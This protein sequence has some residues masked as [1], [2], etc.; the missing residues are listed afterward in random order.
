L[1]ECYPEVV[2]RKE[3]RYLL[4]K[5]FKTLKIRKNVKVKFSLSVTK[6]HAMKA[7]WEGGRISPCILDLGSR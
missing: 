5:K 6:H 1:D 2:P 7:Y 3:L 4:D